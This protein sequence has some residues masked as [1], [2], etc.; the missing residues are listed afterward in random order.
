MESNTCHLNTNTL[1]KLIAKTRLFARQNYI[2][3]L[4]RSFEISNK[5]RSATLLF[6]TMFN[7]TTQILA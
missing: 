4:L 5:L 2:V 3:M 1:S 7:H 6:L